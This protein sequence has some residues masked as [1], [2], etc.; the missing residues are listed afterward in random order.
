[1]LSGVDPKTGEITESGAVS[2]APDGTGAAPM[3]PSVAAPV[4][5]PETPSPASESTKR[6]SRAPRKPSL[7]ERLQV[8][9][10]I[11][12]AKGTQALQEFMAVMTSDE[13]AVVTIQ[14]DRTWQET[15][16]RVSAT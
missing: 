6:V 9:G 12:A 16:E 3:P 8:E 1:V 10:D 5:P 14:M 7:L 4:T 2:G 11:A 13:M 15:A